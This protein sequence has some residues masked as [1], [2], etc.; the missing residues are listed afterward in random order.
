[1]LLRE[2]FA[3]TIMRVT[4]LNSAV[5]SACLR[6]WKTLDFLPTMNHLK[7]EPASCVKNESKG[8][9]VC[10]KTFTA[11]PLTVLLLRSPAYCPTHPG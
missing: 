7:S 6:V 5:S 1:M 8:S 2:L 3:F 9:W 10:W 4:L 11:A